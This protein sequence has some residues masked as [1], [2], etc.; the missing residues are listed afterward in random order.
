MPSI[1]KHHSNCCN[2]VLIY[3]QFIQDAVGMYC[4]LGSH[5]CIRTVADTPAIKHK[6]QDRQTYKR[7]YTNIRCVF[8]T[9]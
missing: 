1:Y 2:Y 7:I 6:M 3:L 5:T 8:R 4:Q 9:C